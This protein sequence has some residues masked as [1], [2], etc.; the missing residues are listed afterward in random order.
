LLAKDNTL[1]VRGHNRTNI[2]LYFDD[3]GYIYG[4]DYFNNKDTGRWDVSKQDELCFKMNA[5]WFGEPRCFT[6]YNEMSK[7]YLFN[8]SGVLVYTANHMEGD[9]KSLYHTIKNSKKNFLLAESKEKASQAPPPPAQTDNEENNSMDNISS[10]NTNK[11]ELKSTVRWMAKDCPDCNLADTNLSRA[12]LIAA[13]LEGANLS[14]AN[15]KNAN[16]RRANLKDANLENAD[17]SYA[18]MPG[19]NLQDSDLTN[20]VFKGANLIRTNFTGA[21]IE[22]TNFEGALLE[23]VE[24]LQQ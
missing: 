3:S 12:N 18:N 9:N 14:G 2:Y 13:N 4:L 6:V 20:A 11:E 16:L 24:G 21:K 22:G 10:D 1:F 5:W 17:L 23:G 19:A 8:T 7:Y 15:L